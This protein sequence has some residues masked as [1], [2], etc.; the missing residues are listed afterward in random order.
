MKTK[1][2]TNFAF[3]QGQATPA[4]SAQVSIGIYDAFGNTASPFW[5]SGGGA[6]QSDVGVAVP[7]FTG[8]V[9]VRGGVLGIRITNQSADTQPQQVRVTLFRTTDKQGV[10]PPGIANQPVGFDVSQLVD[11][12]TLYGKIMMTKTALLENSNVVECVF[13][14]KVH[15]V[16]QYDYSQLTKRFYWAVS[17]GGTESAAASTATVTQYWNAS[18]VADA[19]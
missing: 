18:F 1:Y 9:V 7:T 8:D 4:N 3:T 15:K 17:V 13:R 16:D 5:T 12:K 14:M 2:R 19:V 11:F 6:I 10:A